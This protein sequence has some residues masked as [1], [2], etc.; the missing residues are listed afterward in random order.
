MFQSVASSESIKKENVVSIE[1]DDD[2]VFSTLLLTETIDTGK[3]M[4]FLN[5]F[6][7]TFCVFIYL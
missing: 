5:F 6:I 2:E 3:N 4:I 7:I 1:F